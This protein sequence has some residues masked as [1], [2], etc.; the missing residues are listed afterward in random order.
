MKNMKK[1]VAL[2]LAVLLVFGLAACGAP[3]APAS[4]ANGGGGDGDRIVVGYAALNLSNEFIRTLSDAL[5]QRGEELGVDVITVDAQ[6]VIERQ[7]AA[8][9]DFIAMGVDVIILNP[10]DAEALNPSVDLA[11]EA[12]IPL[13]L[14][15]TFTTN[16]NYV[17]YVGSSNIVSGRIQGEFLAEEFAG[18]DDIYV[19]ILRGVLG[20]S[21]EIERFEGLSET[22][23][24]LPGIN[25]LADQTGNWSR[26]EGMRIME[27]W[28]QRYPRIDVLASHNDE[29]ALGAL[30]AIMAAG[31][32]DDI[33]VVGIDAIADALTSVANGEMSATVFQDA[34]GQGSSAIEVAVRAAR[35]ETVNREYDIPFVLVTPANLADFQ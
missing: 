22:F 4:P 20:H 23:L 19:V 1:M 31:R 7:V 5:E 6:D 12:G 28:L 16:E 30:E 14:V 35:G 21:A 8:V 15:N 13:I 32:L 17:S 18:Q 25:I 29:M 9:E 3:A 10:I 27:D 24:H 33:L 34:A 11:Y 2:A 26:E